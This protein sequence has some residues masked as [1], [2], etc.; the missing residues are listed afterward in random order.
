MLVIISPMRVGL[1]HTQM[2][3]GRAKEHLDRLANEVSAFRQN[4]YSISRQDNANNSRHR[5]RIELNIMPDP[6]GI[7]VGEFAFNIRSGLDHLAWQLA[8]LTTGNPAR[9]T[10][11]PICSTKPTDH[12]FQKKVLNIPPEA[13]DI[14]ESLQPYHRGEAFRDCPLWQLNRLCNIDKHQLIAV[15]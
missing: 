7:L 4:A 8:L 2:K 15:S 1:T 3:L 6:I 10:A 13:V 9:N 5:V 12:S 11:F 14:I